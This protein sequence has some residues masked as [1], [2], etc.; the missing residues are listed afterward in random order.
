MFRADSIDGITIR[1]SSNLVPEA[2]IEPPP[3]RG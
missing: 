3:T 1:N 2:G